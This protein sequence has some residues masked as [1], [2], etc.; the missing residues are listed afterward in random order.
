MATTAA[1]SKSVRFAPDV[2]EN[3]NPK[4]ARIPEPAK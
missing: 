1:P 4:F 3:D 2:V